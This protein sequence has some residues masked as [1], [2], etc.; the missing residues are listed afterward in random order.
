MEE[1]MATNESTHRRAGE[2]LYP[3]GI[4]SKYLYI[5]KIGEVRLMK[6]VNNHLHVFHV[7]KSGEIINDVSVL[8]KKATDH[9]AV[10]SNDSEIV[11]IEV[12]DVRGVLEKCP[13]WVPDIFST[14]CERLIDSQEIIDEHN[15]NS[16]TLDKNF[17][18]SKDA[19][20]K[21]LEAI[22]NYK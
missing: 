14:L 17:I 6:L 12:K 2:I 1:S 20:A 21:I 5:L 10:V 9:V 4:Q 13:K 11:A 15:L 8:T 7:C 18:L 19:E 22:K 3:S 16:G